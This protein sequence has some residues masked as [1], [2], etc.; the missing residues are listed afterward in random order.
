[1]NRLRTQP[2]RPVRA[3]HRTALYRAVAHCAS[4]YAYNAPLLGPLAWTDAG[5]LLRGRAAVRLRHLYFRADGLFVLLALPL[6][7]HPAQSAVG[8]RCST[9]ITWRVN[10]VLVV[11]TNLADAVLQYAE[12]LHGRRDPIATTTTRSH[13]SEVRRPG[14]G[15]RLGRALH[16][17]LCCVYG[18]RLVVTPL[19][20]REDWSRSASTL[21][22]VAL[23]A[24][25]ARGMRGGFTHDASES[26]SP[27]RR[28]AALRPGQ[29]RANFLIPEQPFCIPHRG[30]RREGPHAALLRAAGAF[31]T[32]FHP[33]IELRRQ[34]RG[35]PSR[36]HTCFSSSRIRRYEHWR[37]PARKY[38]RVGGCG[39]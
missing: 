11:A 21:L 9:A 2:D 30:R 25:S 10:A 27:Q 22:F 6:P 29:I 4:C 31:C 32:A 14:S 13:W 8:G 15:P 16:R 18:R 7:T 20:L 39:E 34:R 26:R 35:R 33:R 37:A 3:A 36:T 1:M 17:P 28:V 5:S 23:G 19:L 24:G 38:G 12:A